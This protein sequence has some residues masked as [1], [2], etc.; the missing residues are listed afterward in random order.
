MDWRHAIHVRW[1][2]GVAVAVAASA[3]TTTVILVIAQS[4]EPKSPPV[5]ALHPD[6]IATLPSGTP[7]A[8]LQLPYTVGR[9]RILATGSVPATRAG[10]EPP[11][12][13]LKVAAVGVVNG[14][15]IEEC[16]G[17]QLF[18]EPPY[19]TSGYTFSG[20]SAHTVTW[21]D[22]E[23]THITYSAGFTQSGYYPIGI[24]RRLLAAGEVVDVVNESGGLF[25]L[26]VA[27]LRGVPAIIRHQAP[28][29]QVNGPFQVSFITQGVVTE[30]EGAGIDLDELIRAAEGIIDA[31]GGGSQP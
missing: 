17:F 26:T 10:A 18:V 19:V 14:K 11:R 25:A 3:I 15:K 12:A 27:R 29:A 6:Q 5:K 21:D 16:R 23:T 2:I 9:F 8:A 24:G 22:G 28:G 30:V 4:P 31:T 13:G 1:L 20:C 7:A